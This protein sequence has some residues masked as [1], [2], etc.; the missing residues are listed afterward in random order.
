MYID[1]NEDKLYSHSTDHFNVQT[2]SMKT[3]P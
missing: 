2:S 1:T 3:E